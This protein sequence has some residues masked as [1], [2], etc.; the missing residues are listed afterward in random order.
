MSNYLGYGT[1]TSVTTTDVISCRGATTLSAHVDAGTLTMTW[2]FKG[3][4][5]VW[6]D[7]YAGS[8]NTDVQ[9]YTATNM[10]N[11]YF[12]SDVSVRGNVTAASGLTLDWQIIGS[13]LSGDG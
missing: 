8:D 6:R 12:G 2:Q 7:L 11:L 1:I 13:Y 5:G 9:T 4:D 10:L 3:P